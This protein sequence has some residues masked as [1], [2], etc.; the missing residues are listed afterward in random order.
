MAKRKK[1][2][3]RKVLATKADVKRAKNDAIDEVMRISIMFP[4]KVLH[5][6]FGFGPKRLEIFV[7]EFLTTFDDRCD[8]RFTTADLAEWV[9]D[10]SGISIL[11]RGDRRE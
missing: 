8:D 6:K 2:N 1:T 7:E 11:E 9:K 5:D 10:Y 3:P 4:M